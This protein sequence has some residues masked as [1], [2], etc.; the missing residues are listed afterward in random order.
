M[1]KGS[2]NGR[3]INPFKFKEVAKA[4]FELLRVSFTRAPILIHFNSSRPIKIEIDTLEFA[5]A[6]ILL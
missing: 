3:K 2:I 6:G 4:A 1:L 5:I